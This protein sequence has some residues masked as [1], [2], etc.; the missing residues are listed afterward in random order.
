MSNL[1]S[2]ITEILRKE[3]YSFA[4]LASYLHKSEQELGEELNNNTLELKSLEEISKVLRVPLYSFFRT[5]EI[6]FD[7]NQKPFYVNRL[8]TGDDS[9][10]TK[11]ELIQEIEFLKQIIALKEEQTS[12]L[13]L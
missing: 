3:Q 1:K 7:Y 5:N 2:R 11:Q 10:K 8:W 12:K 9:I 13:T 4:D 6:K